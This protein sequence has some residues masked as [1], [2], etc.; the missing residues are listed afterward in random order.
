[1]QKLETQDVAHWIAEIQPGKESVWVHQTGAKAL[2]LPSLLHSQRASPQL[3]TERVQPII[4]SKPNANWHGDLSTSCSVALYT[5]TSIK[6]RGFNHYMTVYEKKNWLAFALPATS[7][8]WASPTWCEIL[9]A[10]TV[11]DMWLHSQ[12]GGNIY[13]FRCPSLYPHFRISEVIHSH[14][15]WWHRHAEPVWNHPFWLLHWQGD[16]LGLVG[17]DGRVRRVGRVCHKRRSLHEAR[18]GDQRIPGSTVCQCIIW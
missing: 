12:N 4:P 2:R 10:W 6:E 7:I 1:M 14:L 15:P 17:R 13:N 16:G 11:W 3:C 8:S 9:A 18:W 5:T